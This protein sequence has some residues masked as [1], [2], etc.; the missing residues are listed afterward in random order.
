MTPDK[1][2]TVKS[3]IEASEGRIPWLYR[4]SG[5]NGWPTVGIGHAV[6][7]YQSCMAIPFK[8]SIT[9][10]EW[11]ALM[12]EPK[13]CRASFYQAV[14][15]GRL[16]AADIDSLLDADVAA[17]IAQL[18]AVVYGYENLP[19]G[20][21]S[22]LLDMAFNLGVGG[23]TKGY[24]KLMAAVKSGDWQTAAAECHRNGISPGRNQQTA[25][26]FLEGNNG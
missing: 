4:D 10:A 5:P 19:D 8:P 17:K 22:A 20:P 7:D 25:N 2:A 26:L 16:S 6:F 14:T 23:L 21:Q 18:T 3:N 11:A 12:A 15:K 24:P 9:A 13:A 1:L